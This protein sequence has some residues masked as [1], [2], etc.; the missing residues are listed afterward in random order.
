MSEFDMAELIHKE[1]SYTLNGLCFNVQNELG[2]KFQEKHYLKCLCAHLDELNIPYQ[3]EV[4]FTI[5]LHEKVIG[6]FRADLIVDKKILVELK[7]TDYLTSDH[8]Q[9]VVRYLDALGL[10]LGLLV[11]FRIRPLKIWRVTKSRKH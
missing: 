3:T 10:E 11:N 7:T 5:K 8:K 4:S 9:Q 1:L 2:T 6:S